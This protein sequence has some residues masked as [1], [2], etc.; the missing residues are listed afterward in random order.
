MVNNEDGF[1]RENVTAV[2]SIGTST[3]TAASF[4]NGISTFVSVN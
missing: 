1:Q 2:C 4:G 3:K